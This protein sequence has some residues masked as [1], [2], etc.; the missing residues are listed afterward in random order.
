MSE[1]TVLPS[2]VEVTE[3]SGRV[4]GR[5]DL[6]LVVETMRI[7][8][9]ARPSVSDGPP[10]QAAQLAGP[11]R[12]PAW[13]KISRRVLPPTWRLSRSASTCVVAG[14]MKVSTLTVLSARI[15]AAARKSVVFPPVQ[16]PMYTRSTCT[17]ASSAAGARLPGECGA[18]TVGASLP[19]SNSITSA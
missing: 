1:K 19:T 6:T 18:A 12:Q 13:L 9:L 4:T 3:A 5:A 10:R 11:I 2:V 8:S 7:G 17:S 15:I 14:T 16:E